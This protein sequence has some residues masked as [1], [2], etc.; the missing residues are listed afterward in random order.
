M[1][2]TDVSDSYHC[3]MNLPMAPGMSYAEYL[4]KIC[5]ATSENRPFHKL[6]KARML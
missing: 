3:K 5:K 2:P 1:I 6:C 4:I